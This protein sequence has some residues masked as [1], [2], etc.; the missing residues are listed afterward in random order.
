MRKK[1]VTRILTTTVLTAPLLVACG[2]DGAGGTG[3]T[4]DG[5]VPICTNGALSTDSSGKIVCKTFGSD[6]LLLPKCNKDTEAIT[7]PGGSVA[8]CTD[9]NTGA[10][11][12]PA[13]C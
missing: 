5:T 7:S 12:D 6:V 8:N 4:G 11:D 2:T 1:S 3:G 9:R 13:P 10:Q